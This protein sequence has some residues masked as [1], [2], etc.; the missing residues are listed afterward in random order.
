LFYGIT[1]GL[2]AV[3]TWE[4]YSDVDTKVDQEAS[5][6]AAL[7][8]DVSNFPEPSRSELQ[9]DLRE[10]TR[11]L[12]DVGWPLQ[13]R[14]IV[15]QNTAGVVNTIQTHLASFE[16]TTEGQ[17]TLHAEAYRAFTQIVAA[18]AVEERDRRSTGVFMGCPIGRSCSQYRG[19]LVLPYEEQEHALLDDGGFL[20]PPGSADL[21][22]GRPRSPIQ[23]TDQRRARSVRNGV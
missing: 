12:I 16:P 8:R 18:N 2:V 11:Q 13:Q 17:K 7:Y 6:L 1:L 20:W 5:A 14:G 4:A 21:P 19:H 15:P 3:G 23:G 22:P 10:Y 9:A